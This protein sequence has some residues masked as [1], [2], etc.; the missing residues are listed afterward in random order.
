MIGLLSSSDVSQL[1]PLQDRVLIEV[2][3]ADNKTAGGLVLT[4]GAKEKPT[5]GKVGR[6]GSACVLGWVASTGICGCVLN[7]VGAMSGRRTSRRWWMGALGGT[8]QG[9]RLG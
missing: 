8:P 4:E 6:K 3:E 7:G 9:L 1:K 2:L 5:M